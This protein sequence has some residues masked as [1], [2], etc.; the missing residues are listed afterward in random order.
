MCKTN[1]D[2]VFLQVYQEVIST[3]ALAG[4][5]PTLLLLIIIYNNELTYILSR[6]AQSDCVP[7]SIDFQANV[8]PKNIIAYCCMF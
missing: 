1:A 7:H 8:P 4:C 5:P 6:V 2:K 3:Q